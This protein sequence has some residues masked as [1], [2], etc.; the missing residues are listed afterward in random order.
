[1]SARHW[2][3][4]LEDFHIR[5]RTS[6]LIGVAEAQD[7][8]VDCAMP[9]LM[10]VEASQGASDAASARSSARTHTHTCSKYTHTARHGCWGRVVEGTHHTG[11]GEA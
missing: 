5:A 3:I 11:D 7:R 9:G 8:Y 1:M 10:Q 2:P 4:V 6:W